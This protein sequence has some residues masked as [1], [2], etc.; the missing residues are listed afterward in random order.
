MKNR[1]QKERRSLIHHLQVTNRN[2][3]DLIGFLANISEGGIM[4][5]SQNPVTG[6]GE[7]NSRLPIDI[8]LPID[9]FTTSH[10]RI[11]AR[12]VWS[13][14]DEASELYATGLQFLNAADNTGRII[15]EIIL[16]LGS[17]ED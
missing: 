14:Q 10:F 13:S 16:A 4:L 7:G 5:L 1:R 15:D 8:N 12:G 3:G 9:F 6:N 11:D 2:S 17:R